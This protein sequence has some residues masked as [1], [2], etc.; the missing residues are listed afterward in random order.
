MRMRAAKAFLFPIA[1]VLAAGALAGAATPILAQMASVK[2]PDWDQQTDQVL[3][4]VKAH[5]S[6]TDDQVQKI[7][8][9]LRAHLPRMRAL[10]DSYAGM[11]IDEAPALLK[12]YQEIRADFKAKVDPILTEGQRKD[13]MAIRAEFDAEMRKA[14]IDARMGWFEREIGVDVAQSGKLRP[15][16]VDSFEKRLQIFSA[17]SEAKDPATA[18]KDLRIQLQKLQGET[19]A[20]LKT[21]LTPEQMGKYQDLRTAAPEDAAK[22]PTH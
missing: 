17:T 20:R 2:P 5:Y 13:F 18:Q 19:D 15:I 4:A 11:G 22:P 10:F 16:L 6:L 1:V 3:A 9:L 8:P 7:R 14:F 12:Q 21:V